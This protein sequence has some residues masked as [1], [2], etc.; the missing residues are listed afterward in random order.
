M[1]QAKAREEPIYAF[2]FEFQRLGKLTCLHPDI[3]YVALTATAKPDSISAL[4]ETL[5]YKNYAVVAVNP[6]RPN[7]YIEVRTRPPNI[8]K[9][10]KY[11]AFI[12]PL[13]E[14]L[15]SEIDRF[16][17][18]IAY[19]ENLEVL[20]YFYQHL[21]STLKEKQYSRCEQT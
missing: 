13:A 4:A 18:T 12:E 7:I 20:R 10:E 3:A 2:V 14:E 15:N 17:L 6:D 1:A 5:L 8:R 19:V 21:N 9:M 16:P 11:N